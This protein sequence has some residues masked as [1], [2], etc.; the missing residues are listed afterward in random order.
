MRDFAG[1]SAKRPK[2]R[3]AD[4]PYG[5]RDHSPIVDATLELVWVSPDEFLRLER[6]G[7]RRKRKITLPHV[8][9]LD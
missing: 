8:S 2:A 1:Q 6:L 3:A 4:K 5:Y 9:I 7:K